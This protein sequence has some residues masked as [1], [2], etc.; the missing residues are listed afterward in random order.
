MNIL[1][2]DQFSGL[3]G[4]QQCLRDLMP[5]VIERGWKAHV[6]LPPGGGLGLELAAMGARVHELEPAEYTNGR[7]TWRDAVRFVGA[8]PRL[9]AD[10]AGLVRRHR[11][12]TVYANG[13]RVLPAAALAASRVV[14]HSHSLLGARY[15]RL[16]AAASLR[17]RQATAIAACRFV[18]GPL[19][20]HLSAQRLDVVYSGVRDYGLAPRQHLN[21]RAG[22]RIGLIGRIATEKGQTDFLRAAH[23]LRGTFPGCTFVVCGAP[24]YASAAYADEVRNL[25]Q[26]LRVEFPGWQ[27][28]IGPVLRGLD[29]LA[30]PS[31]AIDAAPRVILEAFSAGVPVIAY[32]SG[33]IPELVE[34]GWNG[35]LTA[36]P[37]TKFLAAGIHRLMT[38][39]DRRERLAKHARES[40]LERFTVERFR[41]EVLWILAR[42]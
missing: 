29:V 34:D 37:N 19:E 2:V 30:V 39:P 36:A 21:R 7:K 15:A 9:A 6:A 31:S 24:L 22:G 17:A 16:L 33:G 18:A 26:G 27:R 10:I 1:F 25:A 20:R 40:Y 41:R 23:L 38:D 12:D 42:M 4:G 8:M 35:V 11:I 13:P 5:A 3:G 32:P 28:D 14:F